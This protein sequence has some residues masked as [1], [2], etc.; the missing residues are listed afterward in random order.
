M[1]TNQLSPIMEKANNILAE[2]DNLQTVLGTLADIVGPYCVAPNTGKIKASG[3]EP[4]EPKA[5][6]EELLEEILDRIVG[7]EG[8][9]NDLTARVR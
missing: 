5:P 4:K 3:E 2:L 1:S 9:V 6:L 8:M 7:L